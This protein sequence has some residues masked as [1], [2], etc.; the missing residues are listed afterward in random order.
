[1][2]PLTERQLI[3]LVGAI[4]FAII[5]GFMMM[6]PLGPDCAQA[7]NFATSD[8]GLLSA[9]YAFASAAASVLLARYLDQVERRN[10]LVWSL[11]GFAVSTAAAAIAVDLNSLILARIF[12]GIFSS[13][14][15]SLSIAIIIDRIPEDRRGR[16]LGAVM[17]AFSLASVIGVP[18]GL[19]LSRLLG[20]QA[21]FLLVGGIA[22]VMVMVA[23]RFLPLTTPAQTQGSDMNFSVFSILR[24]KLALLAFFVAGVAIFG[25]FLL[26]P[27]LSAFLQFNLGYPR[28]SLGLLYFIGGTITFFSMRLVG[29]YTDRFGSF[30]V[31]L[32]AVL[33][34]T[35]VLVASF[36]SSPSML[37]AIAVLPLLML[38]NSSRY[39]T[40]TTLVTKVPQPHQRAGFMAMIS[41]VQNLA[42]GGGSIA[43]SALL[44]SAPDGRLIGISAAAGVTLLCAY[45]LLP[46]LVYL[47]IRLKQR[48]T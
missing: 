31:A 1:M 48:M 3:G 20:W 39:V 18:L 7:L 29:G 40:V 13:V 21:P 24:N 2:K 12:A 4:D 34:L 9:A 35:L 30:P 16:A 47:E 25:N 37:P 43:S 28:E 17:G 44:S 5:L 8:I 46:V 42:A 19:E 6:V 23:Q 38:A 26:V 14:A 10:A 22:L 33:L 32:S 15:H 11:A 36:I 45:S 41:A 27:T